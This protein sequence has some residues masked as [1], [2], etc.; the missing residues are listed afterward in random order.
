[1]FYLSAINRRE[2]DVGRCDTIDTR[3]LALCVIE[4]CRQIPKSRRQIPELRWQIL[5][6]EFVQQ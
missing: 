4:Y 1:M 5:T 6:G 2:I 3:N